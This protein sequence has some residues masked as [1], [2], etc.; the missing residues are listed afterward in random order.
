MLYQGFAQSIAHDNVFVDRVEEEHKHRHKNGMG[1]SEADRRAWRFSV[2]KLAQELEA[3]GLGLVYM[4]V[5]FTLDE[6]EAGQ[7][8]PPMDVVLC[9]VH[10]VTGELSFVVVEL[11]QWGA[12]ER[13]TGDPA[14]CWLPGR[15]RKQSKADQLAGKPLEKKYEKHPAVQVSRNRDSLLLHKRLFAD[16]T[17][18]L[19]A[20]AWLHNLT[21]ESGQWITEYVPDR[22][23]KVITGQSPDDLHCYLRDA[24]APESGAGA[25]QALQKDP[26]VPL[27]PVQSAFGDVLKARS[28][29]TLLPEQQVAFDTIVAALSS[30]GAIK[31]SHLVEGGPG[32]GKSV[33][34]VAILSWALANGMS[35]YF[36]SGGTASRFTFQKNAYGFGKRFLTLNALAEKHAPDSV[37]LVVCD[38]A[39]RLP[40]YPPL[41][42]RG[43]FRPGEPSADVVLSRARVSVFLADANQRVRPHEVG[44][45]AYIEGRVRANAPVSFVRHRLTRPLRGSGSSTYD[46]WV[47]RLLVDP[48]GPITWRADSDEPFTL[49]LADSPRQLEQF[50]RGKLDDGFSA[51]IAAG[52]CWEWSSPD[53]MRLVRDVQIGDWSMPWNARSLTDL[54]DAP[55]SQ[56]W[57]TAPG[58]FNQVGCV[59]TAQG[60]E[61]DWGG[62]ILGPDLV[63]RDGGWVGDP[64]ASHDKRVKRAPGEQFEELVRNAYRVLLTRG[65]CGM[66]LYSA[67]PP[68]QQLLRSIIETPE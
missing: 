30:P 68:T 65:M 33:I 35:C 57:A 43:G 45:P 27:T 44:S 25:A 47:R 8:V 39:Q 6:K 5:E 53:G 61:Y 12:V 28:G 58:G 67:D 59:Y 16:R 63:W 51:R 2:T 29:F 55:R 56:L 14:M 18:S 26:T 42:D 15:M 10:P 3:C 32:T 22:H 20:L 62:V 4:F 11:K 54:G 46:T 41:D 31:Q 49:R 1:P 60:L 50:L 64:E 21:A 40:E 23:T 24:F 48:V 37:D 34:G 13:L 17:V 9:G 66:V 52:F 38:E 7:T 36:V 19:S